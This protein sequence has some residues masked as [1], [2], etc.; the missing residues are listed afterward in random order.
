[1]VGLGEGQFRVTT[2]PAVGEHAWRRL[3]GCLEDMTIDRVLARV[4]SKRDIEAP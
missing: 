2:A 1:M 3:K 4:V